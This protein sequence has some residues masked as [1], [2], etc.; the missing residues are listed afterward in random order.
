MPSGPTRRILLVCAT[1]TCTGRRAP[2]YWR[3]T[4]ATDTAVMARRA[5]ARGAAWAGSSP[6]STRGEQPEAC[7]RRCARWAHRRSLQSDSHRDD[8]VGHGVVL[9][10]QEATLSLTL[11]GDGG[12]PIT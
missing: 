2:R 6:L 3:F 4:T 9:V 8:Q 10:A 11:A 12:D 7:F 5:R 1:R